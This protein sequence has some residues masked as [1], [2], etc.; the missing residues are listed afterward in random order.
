MYEDN[1]RTNTFMTEDHILGVITAANKYLIYRDSEGKGGNV[2]SVENTYPDDNRIKLF[3]FKSFASA[4]ENPHQWRHFK[5]K[6]NSWIPIF[7]VQPVQAGQH[8]KILIKNLKFIC[9]GICSEKSY[10]SN[11]RIFEDD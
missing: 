1:V 10:K 5:S 6:E 2:P 8:L 3:N 7:S 9:L 11:R 4:I